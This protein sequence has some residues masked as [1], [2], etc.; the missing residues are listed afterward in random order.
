MGGAQAQAF[1]F[2]FAQVGVKLVEKMAYVAGLG[3]EARSGA[4]D[5]GGIQAEPLRDVDA[6]GRAGNSD[7]QFVR[8]LERGLVE[9][10]G[11]VDHA[12]SVGAVNF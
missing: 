3:A 9:T 7:F 5:N 4:L 1:A 8:G 12:G 6:C 2:G 10:Y 11:G